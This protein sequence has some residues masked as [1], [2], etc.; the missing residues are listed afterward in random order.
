MATKLAESMGIPYME[1]SAKTGSEVAVAVHSIVKITKERL[2]V[3][4]QYKKKK[5]SSNNLCC[6]IL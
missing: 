3:G 6:S 4:K 1:V 5:Q 2:E